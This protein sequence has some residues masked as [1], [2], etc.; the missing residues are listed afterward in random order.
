MVIIVD[1]EGKKALHQLVDIA[2]KAGGI[3][4]LNGTIDILKSVQEYKEPEKVEEKKE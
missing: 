2:L 3:S 1:D 4:N